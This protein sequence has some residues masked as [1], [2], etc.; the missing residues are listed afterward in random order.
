MMSSAIDSSKLSLGAR[1]HPGVL[2]GSR[3]YDDAHATL[4][5]SCGPF[6]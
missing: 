4:Q 1:S 5:V 6:S 2:P 3:S